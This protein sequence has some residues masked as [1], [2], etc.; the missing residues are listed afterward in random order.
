MVSLRVHM[1]SF[2]F[3]VRGDSSDNT[4]TDFGRNPELRNLTQ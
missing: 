2:D 4:D 1:F 3:S